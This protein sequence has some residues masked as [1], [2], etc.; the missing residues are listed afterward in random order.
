MPHKGIL[1][2]S[3]GGVCTITLDR[4]ESMNSLSLPVVEALAAVVKELSSDRSTRVV[5]VTGAGVKVFR[6]VVMK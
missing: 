2:A 6:I 5:V 4:P 1:V 3:S